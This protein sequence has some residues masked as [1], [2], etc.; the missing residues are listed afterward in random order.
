MKV[1]VTGSKG[2]LG[3][4]LLSTLIDSTDYE[5]VGTV[6]GEGKVVSFRESYLSV[7]DISADTD[8]SRALDN[9]DV[10][11]HL[12]A[13]AHVLAESYLDPI[14]EFRRV[15]VNAA[16]SLARQSMAY[17]VKRFIFISSIGVNGSI[18]SSEP[19]TE[20]SVPQPHAYYAVSKYEA[21]T[22]L[23]AITKQS[24]MELVIIRPPLVYAADAP[25]NFARLLKLIDVGLPVPL[26]S[27]K[28]RRSM[29][30]LENL[31]DF[32]KV[33]ISSE[34]A[35]NE[36][37]L[38]SDGKNFSTPEIVHLL[39][40]GMGKKTYLLPIPDVLLQFAA[41]AFR[42]TPI[43]TQLCKSLVVDSAKARNILGWAPPT[44]PIE[45]LVMA[46]Q[47]FKLR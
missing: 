25:G 17:G 10:V 45:A 33:C 30:A 26:G 28:N 42:R 39:A 38:I 1:L 13:R 11:I 7:G 40:R 2:F 43:Y 44:D 6:R 22:E 19:F 14:S 21:E 24:P 36:L 4:H 27:V 32:I 20:D 18:T 5:L 35:A 12:A 41:M 34:A 9:V 3:K 29:I 37:F 23:L 47:N 15:N 16:V 46:G 31:V 8:W